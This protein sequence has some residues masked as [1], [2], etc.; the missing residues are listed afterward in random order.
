MLEKFFEERGLSDS[1]K[2]H[3][4]ASVNLY[5]RLTGKTLN[6]LL[7]EAETE[8]KQKLRWKERKLRQY[9]I[10]FRKYLYENKGE[11][12]ALTYMS[13]IKAIYRQFEIEVHDL[14]VFNSKQI[15]KIYI[16]RYEDIPSKSE[17]IDAY[18]ECSNE[19]QDVLLFA[20][21]TGISKVDFLKLTIDEFIEACRKYF[22]LT[23]QTFPKRDTLIEQLYALKSVENIIPLF[24][25][26]RQKTGSRYTTF[27]SP[28]FVEHKLQHLIGRDASI[29]TIYNRADDEEKE[30]L[31]D[32]LYGAD[33][34]FDISE[35]HLSY[36]FRRINDK[37][38][39]GKVGTSRKL[40]CHQL[41]AYQATTLL[42]V[43]VD[44]RFTE[45]EIDSIQGRVNDKTHRAYLVESV[46]K[47]YCKYR[48]CLDELMLFKKINLISEEEVEEIRK[49]NNFYKKEI[50]ENEKKLEVQQQTIDKI[51]AAQEEIEAMLRIG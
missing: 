4:Y 11:G 38:H 10:D 19:A 1:T 49:E 29:K 51:I 37:L 15:N 2:K 16:K 3:Y 5:Q 13:D 9:L 32:Q 42:N 18:Y 41:R 27:A 50:I 39:L 23:E 33:K 26:C 44:D 22:E 40:R 8:E 30:D 28:E 12:T 31:P 20:S 24:E 14:P 21:S 34:L 47:L 17:L 48:A 43:N 7:Q 45:S 25:G 36:I 35:S 6:E 46:S